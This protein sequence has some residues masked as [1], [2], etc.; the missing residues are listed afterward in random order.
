MKFVVSREALL[1]PLQLVAGVVERRQTLPV[2][3]NVLM[4]LSGDDLSLTGT[5]LEVEIV[6]R[7]QLEQAGD[8]GDITVPARK[9]VDIC[10]SLPD[11]S[12]IEFILEDGRML[13]K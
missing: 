12:N 3:S 1:K 13:V 8:S 10:R 5:E 7:V 11:G 2:L 6:G 4:V 9:L